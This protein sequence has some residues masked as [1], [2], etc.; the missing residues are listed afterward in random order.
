MSEREY[1]AG[2]PD[3]PGFGPYLTLMRGIEFEE[4]TVRWAREVLTLLER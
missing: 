3:L 1:L 2:G 4:S